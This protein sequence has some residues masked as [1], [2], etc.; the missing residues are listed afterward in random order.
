MMNFTFADLVGFT[1][2]LLLLLAYFMQLSNIIKKDSKWY[3]VL[4]VVGAGLS[5]LASIL[6]HY[7]PF[8][9]LEFTW[10]LV[11]FFP[12]FQRPKKA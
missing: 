12:L 11:S 4:N 9:I 2:V 6:I 10:M 1:G 5:C 8:V 7:I 3:I